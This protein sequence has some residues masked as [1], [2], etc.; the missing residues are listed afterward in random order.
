MSHSTGRLVPVSPARRIGPDSGIPAPTPPVWEFLFTPEPALEGGTPRFVILHLTDMSFPA[1]TRLEVDVRYGTDR[2]T[3]DGDA[4]TRPIDPVPGPISIKYFGNG[5]AVGGVTLAEYASGEM[6]TT[7]PG[8]TD[9]DN[10]RT[11]N[12]DVFLE[13]L[14]GGRY[15]EPNF[16]TRARCGS[17]F[18]WT[19]VVCSPTTPAETAA[20]AAVCLIVV[21]EEELVLSTCT[22]TLIGPDLVLSGVLMSGSCAPGVRVGV[23]VV[24]AAM[25][26][27][28][29]LAHCEK[30]RNDGREGDRPSRDS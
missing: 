23:P 12:P 6:K 16:E 4:F 13:F 3:T 8:G 1:G 24:R 15:R 26:A 11:T 5:S 10:T 9:T 18:D 21:R 2:F 27:E 7:G 19:N 14:E 17:S 22:G 28:Q 20:A 30:D 29:I 25:H